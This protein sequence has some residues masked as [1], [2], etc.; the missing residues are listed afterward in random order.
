MLSTWV[1]VTR[2]WRYTTFFNLD[3][4]VWSLHIFYKDV[5]TALID[6]F[7]L[8]SH[9]WSVVLLL[10]L[11]MS[12]KPRHPVDWVLGVALDRRV[13]HLPGCMVLV[14]PM[15]GEAQK[16]SRSCSRCG[17]D[18]LPYCG[19]CRV[20]SHGLGGLQIAGFH[21]VAQS[22]QISESTRC[23]K[24]VPAPLWSSARSGPSWWTFLGFGATNYFYYLVNFETLGQQTTTTKRNFET[25][26]QRITTT[27]WWIFR[28]WD[29]KLL[30][31]HRELWD[32]GTTN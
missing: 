19:M 4:C 30:L 17:T 20:A 11:H 24:W 32:F 26:G 10:P 15:W 13:D 27:T 3:I 12:A 16:G 22:H 28:L 14:V 7:S 25:L 2:I 21:D 18:R 23:L 31:L 1:F 6:V 29:T 8:E 9:S 5:F